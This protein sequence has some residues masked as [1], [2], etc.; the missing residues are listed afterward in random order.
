MELSRR[1]F[2]QST[3]AVAAGAA[4]VGSLPGCTADDIAMSV[5]HA[6]TNSVSSF[7]PANEPPRLRKSFYDLTD[8]EL[9]TFMS[10]VGYCRNNLTLDDPVMWD[11]YARIHAYHCTEASDAHPPVHWSWNFLP[12]HRGYLYFLE[13]ILASCLD[14]QGLDGSK[15][16]MPYWDWTAHKTMPNTRL[17][18]QRGE[19]SPFFGWDPSLED[20]VNPDGLT[21]DNSALYDGN[22]GPSITKPEMDPR[23]ELTQDSKDHVVEC[24]KYM[25]QPY[26]ELMLSSP[27]EQFLGSP[28]V[29]RATGQGLLEQG[30]HNDGHDWVGSRFGKNRTMGTLRTAAGDPMF[31]MHHCNIDRIWSLYEQPQPDPYGDWGT[32]VYNFLD[33][34]GSTITMNVCGIITELKNITYAPSTVSLK[35]SR[36]LLAA[37]APVTVAVGQVIDASSVSVAI[38]ADLFASA[39]VTLDV[40]TG[41]IAYTGKYSVKIQVDGVTV[42]R[43]SFL[44]G[45]YRASFGTRFD[46]HVFR[47]I[48][49]DP[50]AS[51]RT[52]TF[53]P[54]KRG[55]FAFKI[56]SIT[57]TKL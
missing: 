20:M 19:A 29:D 17:R 2:I 50:I 42:G 10:A 28:T 26:V 45:E 1:K 23:N 33:T 21:F 12:W 48:V 41:T 4:T 44:D 14:K 39:P 47:T 13:R 8:D 30:P 6:M 51:A 5:H 38:P 31:Y 34:D 35:A 25:S 57:V 37:P 27:W 54:P 53:V 55:T 22:R 40:K 46:S 3:A 9:K 56:E 49:T 16:A 43:L 32:Q 15:F 7:N 36:K 18:E 52:L 11:N 24:L